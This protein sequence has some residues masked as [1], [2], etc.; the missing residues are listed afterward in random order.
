MIKPSQSIASRFGI[1][2]PRRTRERRRRAATRVLAC[3]AVVPFAAL[4]L[5]L[6]SAAPASA[7]GNGSQTF[8]YTGSSQTYTV[9]PGV[10]QIAVTGVGA[11]GGSG[12]E[13]LFGG[14]GAAGGVGSTAT[15]QVPVTPGETLTVDVGGHGGNGADINTGAGG[16]IG[17]G[18]G[19]NGGPGGHGGTGGSGGGGGGGGGATTLYDASGKL[20]LVAGGGGGGGGGGAVIGYNGG[21]G[22]TG[23]PQAGGGGT[24]GSG[25]DAG[26][27][28]SP[29]GGGRL[30]GQNGSGSPGSTSSGGGGGGGGGYTGGGGGG[31]G[32][33]GG[34]GGGGGAAGSSYVEASAIGTPSFGT[35]GT[36][37]NGEVIISW[38]P[39]ATTTTISASPNPSS[40]NVTITATV[41]PPAGVTSPAPTGTVDFHDDGRFLGQ[42][43]L[44]G[45]TP[46]QAVFTTAFQALS[47]GTHTLEADYLG[48]NVYGGSSSP[49]VSEQIGAEGMTTLTFSRNPAIVGQPLTLTATVAGLP[50]GGPT[51][52]GSVT[53]CG[54]PIACATVPLNGKSPDTATY[55]TTVKSVAAAT[56]PFTASY[57]GDSVY[58]FAVGDQED[59]PVVAASPLSVAT[60]FLIAAEVPSPYSD[61]LSATGGVPPYRWSIV[62]GSLPSGFTLNA[63]TGRI[64][65]TAT[66]PGTAT[67]TVKVSDSS[68][69]TANSAT[70]SLTLPVD[71]APLAITT[72]TLASARVGAAYSATLGAVGGTMPYHWSIA[73]GSLP[74]GLKLNA[75]TGAITGTPTTPGTA[76]FTA[77]VLDS[78]LPYAGTQTVALTLT[79][80]AT[81]QPTVFVSNGG[82]SVVNGFS[83]GARGNSSPTSSLDGGSTDLEGP[84]GLVIDSTGR[85]YVASSEN[86][87]IAEFANAANGNVAP[88]ATISGPDTGLY[89][90]QAVTLDSSG[91]LYVANQTAGTITVYAHGASGDATPVRTISGPLTGLS[92]PD[93][94]AIDASG[95]LWVANYGNNSLTAYAP[96]ANG[97]A[98]PISTIEG[99][100]TGLD[101]PQ[102]LTIDGSGNLLVADTFA[103]SLTE[104]PTNAN[105]N[106]SPLRTIT[107][108]ALD[109]PFGVDVD[110][111]G[112]IYVSNE[113][114]SSVTIYPPSAN[115]DATP[116]GTIS[117]S[118]TGLSAPGPIAV[119]PPLS[120]TTNSLPSATLGRDYHA[121]LRAA[122]GTTPYHWSFKRGHL[123]R[124]LRL[125]VR[126]G[127]LSG[128]P[129]R[130]GTSHFTVRVTDASHPQMVATERLT[131]RV[132]RPRAHANHRRRL[133]DR[134]R[135][136]G[137]GG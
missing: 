118:A 24:G 18:G 1:A 11:P 94:L 71:G 3:L 23:G 8:G 128:R 7:A 60:N 33:S 27:G 133:P 123:P 93:A 45:S 14:G 46:D 115:G 126:T 108:S 83:L 2:W 76:S 101:A 95:N 110:S 98:S 129:T 35:A 41:T 63:S 113:F 109:F 85:L 36:L 67:F 130:L 42:A 25:L 72:L 47:P 77:S 87:T 90:P 40:S 55:T 58:T 79:V 54:T 114:A 53:F 26:S 17:S 74:A 134:H 137:D 75:S 122:L 52:T 6:V 104:Y 73:S 91:N 135:S 100:S 82:N 131:I 22:G 9:P 106:V 15:A 65:G 30:L 112:N 31:A 68:V 50:A 29:Q 38:S 43:T 32:A 19:T 64:T 49:T 20:L 69:P 96:G 84:G 59:L 105:G 62:S 56:Y 119:S 111:Q 21:A 34:G 5:S 81:V 44:N 80:A 116:E 13:G 4:A 88:V 57:S 92:S 97:D 102:G 10:S 16:G 86:N 127:G 66:T 136:G 124:G 48:D 103:E 61:Y 120:V 117:G 99:Y 78:S 51:P 28:G 39:P 125:N 12:L 107:G 89:Y 70:K 121:T 132:T 37:A